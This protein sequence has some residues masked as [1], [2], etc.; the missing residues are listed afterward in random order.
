VA[1]HASRAEF[2]EHASSRPNLRE[3]R[4]PF[5]PFDLYLCTLHFNLSLSS[6]ASAP[7]NKSKISTEHADRK[8]VMTYG[9]LLGIT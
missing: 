2:A 6:V 4:G 1:K 3:I 8:Q 9:R 5:L 7:K